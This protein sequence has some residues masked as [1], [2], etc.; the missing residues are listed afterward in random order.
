MS[1]PPA[2]TL[3]D[4]VVVVVVAVEE[5]L[6]AREALPEAFA[7]AAELPGTDPRRR[8]VRHLNCPPSHVLH[9]SGSLVGVGFEPLIA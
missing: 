9:P 4:V 7:G 2:L 3:A 1:E 5:A 6:A 8:A